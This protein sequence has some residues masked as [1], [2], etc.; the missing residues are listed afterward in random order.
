MLFI[1]LSIKQNAPESLEI[2]KWENIFQGEGYGQYLGKI[3][4]L[5][6]YTYMCV[7]VCMYIYRCLCVYI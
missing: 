5:S 2:K 7:Y 1:N 4:S 6:A 3:K